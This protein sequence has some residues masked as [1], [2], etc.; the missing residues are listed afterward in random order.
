MIIG[1]IYGRHHSVR[2]RD[3]TTTWVKHAYRV[4]KLENKLKKMGVKYR[5]WRQLDPHWYLD[6]PLLL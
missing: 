4:T 2:E 3:K 5:R 1:F 6:S